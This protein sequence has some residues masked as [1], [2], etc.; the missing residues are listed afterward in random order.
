MAREV[1]KH[2]QTFII[3]QA[4]M[5]RAYQM[6]LRQCLQQLMLCKSR[7]LRHHKLLTGLLSAVLDG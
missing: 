1:H 7:E 5:N 4:S 6:E 2:T 3:T